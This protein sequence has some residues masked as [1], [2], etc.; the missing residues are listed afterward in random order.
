MIAT[1]GA[2]ED[3]LMGEYKKIQRTTREKKRTGK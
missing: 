2:S 1:W 3:Q